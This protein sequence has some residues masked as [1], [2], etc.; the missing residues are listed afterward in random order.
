MIITSSFNL[1]HK[2]IYDNDLL[3][4]EII[5]TLR[6]K[7][8]NEIVIEYGTMYVR[9]STSTSIKEIESLVSKKAKWIIQ[10]IKEQENPDAVIKVPN[11]QNNSTLP[12]LGRN[13]RLRII[14]YNSNQLSFSNDE[15][16]I[17]FTLLIL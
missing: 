15:F 9:T 13:C 8:T 7:K 4:F 2:I 1:K 3:E 5:R 16:I 10:K 6:R 17:Y 11:Y 14:E 12:Y